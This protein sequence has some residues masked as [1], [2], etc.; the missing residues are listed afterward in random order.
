[1]GQ[2]GIGLR[3]GLE[4]G[5]GHV[6]LVKVQMRFS[7]KEVGFRW[8]FPL[9]DQLGKSLF[10]PILGAWAGCGNHKNVEIVELGGGLR[11]EWFEGL[12][13]IGPALSKEIALAEEMTG[14]DRVRLIAQ[15]RLEGR[16]RFENSLCR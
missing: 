1:E 13:G 14:L 8:G 12:H 15:H 16:N 2:L 5:Q 7:P 9:P 3:S 4:I 11:P 6:V 10:V